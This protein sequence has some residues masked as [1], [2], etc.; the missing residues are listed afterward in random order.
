[1]CCVCPVS[2]STVQGGCGPVTFFL[3]QDLIL[4]ATVSGVCIKAFGYIR[5]E[6][7]TSPSS[8][9][10]EKKEKFCRDGHK[11]GLDRSWN[12]YL[13][14]VCC[15]Q[16]RL[17]RLCLLSFPGLLYYDFQ[18]VSSQEPSSSTLPHCYR[19]W[20]RAAQFPSDPWLVI[21]GHALAAI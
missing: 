18:F 10:D 11:A 21:K 16:L 3:T 20:H 19:I 7:S 9:L 13:V 4:S 2:N 8:T 6:N 1:M 5:W 17:E 15:C 14:K 12:L